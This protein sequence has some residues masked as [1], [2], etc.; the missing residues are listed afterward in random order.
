MPTPVDLWFRESLAGWVREQLDSPE[1]RS[2]GLLD[3]DYVLEAIE[4]HQAGARDRSLDLWKMLN[5][6]TWW[7]LHIAKTVPIPEPQL[8]SRQPEPSLAF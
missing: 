4:Q 6:V 7:R 8:V 2:F 3:R 1:V 5:L